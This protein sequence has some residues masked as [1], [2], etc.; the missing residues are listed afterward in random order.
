M[1]PNCKLLLASKG[2][3]IHGTYTQTHI[4]KAKQ[5][6]KKDTEGLSLC[7]EAGIDTA[8]ADT[9]NEPSPGTE[10]TVLFRTTGVHSR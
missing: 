10:A 1:V 3:Q 4:Y 2:T 8:A 6:V 5:N 9:E 7:K